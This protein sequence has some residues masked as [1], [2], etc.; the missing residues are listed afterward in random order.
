MRERGERGRGERRVVRHVPARGQERTSD[1][2]ARRGGAGAA[3]GAAAGGPGVE[4]EAAEEAGGRHLQ[5]TVNG[6]PETRLSHEAHRD[7]CS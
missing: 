7:E 2:G 3:P 6:A 1:G 5:R 4:E